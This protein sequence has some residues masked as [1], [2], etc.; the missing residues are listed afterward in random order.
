MS[1]DKSKKQNWCLTVEEDPE[2]GD[3]ILTFLATASAFATA[4]A[5]ANSVAT[6]TVSASATASATV[7][8]LLALWRGVDGEGGRVWARPCVTHSCAGTFEIV[9]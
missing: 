2:T 5:S 1:E 3:G 8:A 9:L 4:T 6:A 7:D